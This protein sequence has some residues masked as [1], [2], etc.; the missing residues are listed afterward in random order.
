MPLR[1]EEIKIQSKFA[2]MTPEFYSRMRKILCGYD[3][4]VKISR[5]FAWSAGKILSKSGIKICRAAKKNPG[6]GLTGGVG[7]LLA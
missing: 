4:I 7:A 3:K 5:K 1:A 2:A 6:L